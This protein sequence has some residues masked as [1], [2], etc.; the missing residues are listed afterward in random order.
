MV[1]LI[2]GLYGTNGITPIKA[3]LKLTSRN[4]QQCIKDKFTLLC[5]V[6]NFFGIDTQHALDL[7]A[8]IGTIIACV[9]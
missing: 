7:V 4:P 8:L 3:E 9:A 6:P 2:S 5:L 1:V